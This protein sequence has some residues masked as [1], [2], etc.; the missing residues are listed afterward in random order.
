MSPL[1]ALTLA[2]GDLFR[3]RIMGVVALGVA[4]TIGLFLALQ[5]GALWAIRL[6]APEHLT[7]PWIGQIPVGGA[8]SWGSLVLLPLMGFFL[9]APVAAAFSGLFAESV[10][11]AV[12]DTHYPQAKGLPVAFWDG[13]LESAALLGAVL[14]VSLLTLVLTPF[15]GPLAWLVFY[16]GN[17]WLLGREFFQMAASRHLRPPQATALRRRLSGQVTALGILIAL[18]LTVP[19]LNI[20]VPVLAAAAFTHLF[21]LTR[22]ASQGP[23]G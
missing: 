1:H 22:S 14:L 18:L 9:M 8:L 12:E 17:G 10:A 13:L 4:L 3:P 21:H 19:V 16:G 11:E 2:W 15:L 6:F 20:L 7:L 5:A 23:R